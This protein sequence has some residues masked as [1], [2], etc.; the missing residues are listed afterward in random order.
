MKSRLPLLFSVCAGIFALQTFAQDET[1]STRP[2]TKPDRPT[3]PEYKSPSTTTREPMTDQQFVYKAAL[4]G[5]KEIWLS[6]LALEKSNNSEVKNFAQKMIADH[7]QVAKQLEQVAKSK[8]L[9]VPPTN[10]F[11]LAIDSATP[12]NVGGTAESPRGSEQRRSDSTSTD[13]DKP[14][15]M[16]QIMPSD[17][18]AARKLQ[19]QTGAEFDK[20]Y[21]SEMC[22]DHEKTISKFEQASRSATDTELKQFAS[23]TLTK[24]REHNQM[25]E[26]LAQTV[27]AKR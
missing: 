9:T 21:V 15:G 1:P 18:D 23:D 14:F 2:P 26:Q 19:N 16:T 12:P 10:A 3:S 6:Q 7:S 5:Q 24:L 22:K 4:G 11:E 13:Q 27:G 25:A 17:L 8:G 20:T